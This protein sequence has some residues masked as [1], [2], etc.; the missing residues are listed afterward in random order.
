M[1][2]EPLIRSA[3]GSGRPG[4]DDQNGSAQPATSAIGSLVTQVLRGTYRILELLDEGGMGRLYRAEHIRLN[5]PIA[6]KVLAQHLTADASALTRFQREAA[7]VSQLHH[8]HIVHILDFDT[9]EYGAP[10]IVMELLHGESL[11]KRLDRERMLPL[12]DVVEI[13]AQ[14]ASALNLAHQQGIVHRDLKPD[15]VFLLKVD[16]GQVFVKLLDFGISKSASS[17]AKVTREFDVL[18][19]PDYM[20]PEQAINTSRAD[21]RAD[22]FSLGAMTYEMLT[23]RMPF[24]AETLPELLRKLVH[25]K[26]PPAS[27]FVSGIGPMVDYVLMRAMAKVPDDRFASVQEFAYGL[28]QATGIPLRSAPPPRTSS[29]RLAPTSPPPQPPLLAS[30]PHQFDASPYDV[31][32]HEVQNEIQRTALAEMGLPIPEA[33]SEHW[34][35]RDRRSPADDVG[36]RQP[37]R[38]A[39]RS[40]AS[41]E[42]T[43]AEASKHLARPPIEAGPTTLRSTP[44]SAESSET[45]QFDELQEAITEV[46]RA[47]AFGEPQRALAHARRA[48]HLARHAA[49]SS[50]ERGLLVEASSTLELVLLPAVGGLHKKIAIRDGSSAARG[51][52]TPEHFFLISRLE[53]PITVEELLDLSPFSRAETL[54][55][56]ADLIDQHIVA[57]S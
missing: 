57:L 22:Q 49:G 35:H 34:R 28:A 32:R 16:A 3:D 9:T 51:D 45:T 8:P 29:T 21:H 27:D 48:V 13:V 2:T 11:A 7:I 30:L 47:V 36:T 42:H 10:Y 15:N 12:A 20:A 31:A 33:P 39:L 26:P 18:G 6:V 50:Q 38:R 37:V 44:R 17:I 19:T 55:F 52:L 46:R 24:V 23:G 56:I 43:P 4:A 41:D 54:G 14:I 40:H 5:R 53:S 1:S 25:E